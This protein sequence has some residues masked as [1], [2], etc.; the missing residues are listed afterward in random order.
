MP[1]RVP[2]GR[3]EQVRAMLAGEAVELVQVP[4]VVERV[5]VD[6]EAV[7]VLLAGE[8]VDLE[9]IDDADLEAECARRGWRRCRQRLRHHLRRRVSAHRTAT[10][11]LTTAWRP[12]VSWG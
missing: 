8:A 4:E 10:V 7:R 2:V 6:L 1:V 5:A 3:V 9:R 12:C 11:P